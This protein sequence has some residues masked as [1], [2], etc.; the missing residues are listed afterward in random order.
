MSEKKKTSCRCFGCVF[1]VIIIAVLW[2]FAPSLIRHASLSMQQ[3]SIDEIQIK[4]K[5]SHEIWRE[6]G[7]LKSESNQYAP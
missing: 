6:Y 1:A 2:W 7:T 5:P 3:T 4:I